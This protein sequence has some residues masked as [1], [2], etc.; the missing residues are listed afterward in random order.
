MDSYEEWVD[1]YVSFMEDYKNNPSDMGVLSRSAKF[2][3]KSEEMTNKFDDWKSSCNEAEL[4]YYL[5][6]QARTQQK[7]LSVA[8]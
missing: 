6:V 5:E 7:L 4:A 8:Q 2:L 3:G 1:E